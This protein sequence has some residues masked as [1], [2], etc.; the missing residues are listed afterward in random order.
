MTTARMEVQ[1]ILDEENPLTIEASEARLLELADELDRLRGPIPMLLFCPR[2]HVQHVDQATETWANPPH[3]THQCL[4]CHL[5]WRPSN[6]DTTGVASIELT[7]PKHRDAIRAAH[8]RR[9]QGG[10]EFPW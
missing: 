7:K 5:L 2:C 9:H 1:G 6:R 3:A 8:P 10:G 4:N